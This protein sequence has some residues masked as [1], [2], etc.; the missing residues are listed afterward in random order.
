VELSKEGIIVPGS[1]L[2]RTRAAL[3]LKN[4][5]RAHAIYSR[6][7][8]VALAAITNLPASWDIRAVMCDRVHTSHDREH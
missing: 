2:D 6:V 8:Y 5:N 1:A 3:E 7:F 4:H